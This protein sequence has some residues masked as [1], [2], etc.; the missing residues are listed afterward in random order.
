MLHACGKHP[1]LSFHDMWTCTFHDMYL[2][3][4][5]ILSHCAVEILLCPGLV[6]GVLATALVEF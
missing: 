2:E 4:D 3:L 1:V 5:S 6:H